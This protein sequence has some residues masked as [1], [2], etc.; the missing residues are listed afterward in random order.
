MLNAQ[1]VA[2]YF[3][4]NQDTGT[5]EPITNLKIQKLCYYAQGYALA[6]LGRPLFFDDIEHWKHGPVVQSLWRKYSPYRSGAI[7][8]PQE[9]LD[10]HLYDSETTVL[11]DKVSRF[12]GRFSAWELRNKTHNEPPWINT[13]DGCPITHLALRGYFES[14]SDLDLPS[15]GSSGEPSDQL[16]LGGRMVADASF[17]KLTERGLADISSGRYSTLD[18]VKRRLKDV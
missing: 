10:Q 5:S 15:D 18:D 8:V 3:L 17:R 16:G 13:P 4:A 7:P 1:A 11:L 14:L 6:R 12:Y 2:I 9:P